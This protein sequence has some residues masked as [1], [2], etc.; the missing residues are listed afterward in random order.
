MSPP[1]DKRSPARYGDLCTEPPFRGARGFLIDEL[2]SAIV[3]LFTRKGKG[4]LSEKEF[5]LSASMDLRWFPP[6]DAQRLLQLGIETGL[7]ESKAGAIRPTFDVSAVDVPRDFAPAASVFQTPTPVAEDLFVAIVDAIAAHSGSERRAVIAS[8]NAV[9]ERLDVDVE[10]AAL[11]AARKAG[12]DVTRF[13]PKVR[14][15]LGMS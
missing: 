14:A 2:R 3:V 10:V 8:V 4:E 6:K 12:L 1:P 5:V 7:L 9:Q 15:R 11:V 13:V